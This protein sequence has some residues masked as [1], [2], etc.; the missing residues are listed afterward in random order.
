ML[1][2][3][4]P[5]AAGGRPRATA[6]DLPGQGSDTTPLPEITLYRYADAVCDALAVMDGP[7]LS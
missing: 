1:G 7:V 2:A 6:I 4:D 5:G 3:C